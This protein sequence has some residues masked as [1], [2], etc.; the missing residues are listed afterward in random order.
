MIKLPLGL[1]L[2]V[3]L[4]LLASGCGPVL[5]EFPA[6]AES[7]WPLHRL[8]RLHSALF[9]FS[10]AVTDKIKATSSRL[11]PV[12]TWPR[13]SRPWLFVLHHGGCVVSTAC[14]CALWRRDLP[15]PTFAGLELWPSKNP[16]STRM[17]EFTEREVFTSRGFTK[18]GLV[19]RLLLK[20]R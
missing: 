10:F 20:P 1:L 18:T 15:G 19:H 8:E 16:R 3:Q 5:P 4:C 13:S 12:P 11:G 17:K 2:L 9:R 6:V 7:G 14:R